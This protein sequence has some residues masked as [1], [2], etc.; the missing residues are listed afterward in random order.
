[1]YNQKSLFTQPSKNGKSEDQIFIKGKDIL[2]FLLASILRT[3]FNFRYFKNEQIK[4][5]AFIKYFS[6]LE[7]LSKTTSWRILCGEKPP[8]EYTTESCLAPHFIKAPWKRTLLRKLHNTPTFGTCCCPI[9]AF[10]TNV[11]FKR[12]CRIRNLNARNVSRYASPS[13]WYTQYEM[14][15]RNIAFLKRRSH[16]ELKSTL[17]LV[18]HHRGWYFVKVCLLYCFPISISNGRIEGMSARTRTLASNV[19]CLQM[20]ITGLKP[21]NYKT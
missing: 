3:K 6:V 14:S 15:E 13:Q 21:I 12:M 7:I 1:M 17:E 20:Q 2:Q 5:F 8:L 18:R 19:R 16:W 4:L 10:A 11:A 9:D